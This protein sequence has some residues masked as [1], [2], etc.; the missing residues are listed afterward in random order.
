[1]QIAP[2]VDSLKIN[3]QQS[4]PVLTSETGSRIYFCLQRWGIKYVTQ[5]SL[6][7]LKAHI[8]PQ[9][10]FKQIASQPIYIILNDINNTN[11]PKKI[12]EDF[13]DVVPNKERVYLNQFSLH[14]PK[15]VR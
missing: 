13:N 11:R 8:W 9:L 14:D 15:A 3:K 1:M 2:V 10:D 7:E 12:I 4:H 5:K 6:R